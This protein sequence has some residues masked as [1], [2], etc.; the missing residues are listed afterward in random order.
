M[1]GMRGEG[2][3]EVYPMKLASVCGAAVLALA[4]MSFMGQA[5]KPGASRPAATRPAVVT[6][7]DK[8]IQS[9]PKELRPAK[10]E[11]QLVT[12]ER[13]K[14]IAEHAI[15]ATVQI[16]IV[17]NDISSGESGTVRISSQPIQV[18]HFGVT[19]ILQVAV[20]IPVD[21]AGGFVKNKKGDKLTFVGRIGRLLVN[22]DAGTPDGVMIDNVVVRR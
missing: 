1:R 21:L 22:A 15:G 4:G 6:T 20:E 16:P 13:E 18:Q 7:V 17:V 19:K 5:D 11:T 3:E 12:A 2:G 14:W 9:I 8:V 10:G